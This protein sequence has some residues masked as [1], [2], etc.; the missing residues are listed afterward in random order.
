MRRS[1]SVS[2]PSSRSSRSHS[3]ARR[4]RARPDTSPG[5]PIRPTRTTDATDVRH[6]VTVADPYRWLEDEKSPEVQAWM[7]A[8]DDLARAAR[9]RSCRSATRSPRASRSSSTS[10]RSA[11][12]STAGRATSTRAATPTRRRRSSTGRKG[13]DGAEQVLLDPNAWCADGSVSLGGVAASRWDGK[14]VAYSDEE[15]QLRRG[16][17]LRD[18]RRD[19]QGL[20]R[21]RHRGRQVRARVVDARRRRLLLH[22]AARRPD[23][24]RSPSAPA[25]PRSAS[26]SSATDPKKDAARPRAR[27]AIRRRSSARTSRA[28][29]TGC[30]STVSAR[31]DVAP[32]STSAT[33]RR[34]PTTGVDAAR[35]R[36][37]G[38]LQR[39]RVRTQRS[40]SRPTTARRSA[41][42]SPSIRRS[43]ARAAWKEIVPERTD[44][45]LE[46]VAV[47][48]GQLA[49]DYLKNAASE[50]EIR[51]PRRQARARG[52]R[53]PASAPSAASSGRDD[54]DE[55]YFAFTSF[56]T[57]HD[58]LQDVDRRPA[59][60]QLYVPG[61]AA[62][63][64][65]AVH[66]RAG[67]LSRRR[68]ARASRCS[69]S[70]ART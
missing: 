62:R 56:T 38:A 23:R 12:R 42:S 27:P 65:V 21:R 29:A 24:S 36:D 7:K 33:S 11:P 64:P 32:T 43:P 8:Q 59:R 46:G 55:A 28:T 60:R 61:Q 16:D 1:D 4:A 53:S 51:E 70:T 17:A 35:R 13:E 15:Q 66:R 31:L 14:R 20:R 45:T 37:Q 25:S 3:R 58:D 9:S 69:S 68:T 10:T 67:V 26:T 54:E 63:R 47:V 57:P 19:R 6:G 40:T 18:G 34:T 5:R 49:L 44:A 52:R 22:V 41:A 48:G 39:R 30:S 2:S 50:L